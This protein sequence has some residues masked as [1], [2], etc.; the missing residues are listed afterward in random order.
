MSSIVRNSTPEQA[1]HNWAWQILSKLKLHLL[2]QPTRLIKLAL[3]DNKLLAQIPD[4]NS[5]TEVMRNLNLQMFLSDFF[6]F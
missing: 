2:D 6:K 5:D 1:L 4:I 3:T